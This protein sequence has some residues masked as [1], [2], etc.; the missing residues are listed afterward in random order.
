MSG[1]D[2]SG[3]KTEQPTA[4]R[5][6]DARR[7]GDVPKSSDLSHTATTLV[8]T[9]LI[10]GLGGYYADR[11][12]GLLE[13]AWTKVDLTSPDAL[14]DVG[15]AAAYAAV[16]L[17]VLPIG[18]VAVCGMLVEFLQV[19]PV[20]APKR[21]APQPARLSPGD[22]LKRVFSL[23]NLV[24]VAKALIK[25]AILATVILL[26]LQHYLTDILELPGAGLGAYMDLDR[27]LLLVLCTWIVVLFAFLSIGDRL[28]QNYRH[29]KRLRMSKHDLR[30]ER[31]EEDGDPHTRGQRKRLHKQ[32]ATQN[33]RQAAREATAVVVNP[34]HI[35]IAIQYEPERTALPLV[36]AKGEGHLA[37]L[38]RLEAES[39]GVP[40]I[41]DIPLARALHFKAEEQELIPE[42]F[43]DAIV[44]VIACAERFRAS[45]TEPSH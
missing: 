8:W 15:V 11:L 21:I 20:F 12:G 29:R 14:L 32:W 18:V 28:F 23:D 3:E 2:D 40:V 9:L 37:R 25:T 22:G 30:Q 7:E 41:R 31:K 17:T 27:R 13:L 34:V 6:R 24:E 35:A 10:A 39:A 5:L 26:V 4:K 44:E 33:A 38:M 45:G 16:V 43:F 36:T 19:G 42:E 1:H